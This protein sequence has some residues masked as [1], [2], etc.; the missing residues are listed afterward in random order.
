MSFRRI[1]ILALLFGLAFPGTSASMSRPSFDV[2]CDTAV[3]IRSCHPPHPS[4]SVLGYGEMRDKLDRF[5]AGTIYVQLTSGESRS[6]RKFAARDGALMV[7][8]ETLAFDEIRYFIVKATWPE[9]RT[10]GNLAAGG[11]ILFG[12]FGLIVDG[13]QWVGGGKADVGAT[14]TGGIIG[15][16]LFGGLGILLARDRFEVMIQEGRD[17]RMVLFDPTKIEVTVPSESASASNTSSD[18]ILIVTASAK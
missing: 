3:G 16:A 4:G 12:S 10:V 11:A 7:G 6:S 8:E 5:G 13:I 17:Q 14:L 15:A 1:F 9:W 2:L 18:G